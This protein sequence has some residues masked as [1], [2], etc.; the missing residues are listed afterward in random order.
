MNAMLRAVNTIDCI[1]P[2]N[3]RRVQVLANVLLGVAE[4]L[5]YDLIRFGWIIQFIT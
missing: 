4:V 1:L 5:L 3:G 2:K